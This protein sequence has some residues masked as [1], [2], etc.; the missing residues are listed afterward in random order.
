[1]MPAVYLIGSLTAGAL[2][3]L[4]WADGFKER[5]RGVQE[6]NT[7]VNQATNCVGGEDGFSISE[8]NELYRRA[9]SDFRAPENYAPNFS[10]TK[11]FN[12]FQVPMINKKQLERVVQGCKLEGKIK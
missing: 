3:P 8:I 2:N 10:R 1:M 7:L 11:I 9:G 5:Q 6:R 12:V 4:G